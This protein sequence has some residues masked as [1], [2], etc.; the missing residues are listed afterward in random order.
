MGAAREGLDFVK[1]LVNAISIK[2]GG[3][4]VVLARLLGAMTAQRPDI[5][6]HAAIHPDVA[7]R[8][9]LPEV[10]T[11]WTFPKSTA[12]LVTRSTGTRSP[13]RGSFGA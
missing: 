4:L 10:V 6:W 13:C 9:A 5:E 8:S 2:E 7:A 12:R 11:P 1:V 3:S